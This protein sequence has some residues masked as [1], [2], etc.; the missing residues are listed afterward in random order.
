MLSV[1]Q[2][3]LR[4]LPREHLRSRKR[5][6]ELH[7][8][9]RSL[10]QGPLRIRFLAGETDGL[11]F[12]LV[13]GKRLGD[14]VRRNRIKRLLREAYR[15]G[16]PEGAKGALDFLVFVGNPEGLELIALRRT[17]WSLIARALGKGHA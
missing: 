17:L 13:V 9:G 10:A 4:L 15:T 2:Q 3:R 1:G 11:R 5:I 16:R 14:A 7:R 6:A 12:A 8:A